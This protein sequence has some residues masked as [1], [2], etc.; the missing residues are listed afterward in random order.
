[1]KLKNKTVDTA[2]VAGEMFKRSTLP[3]IGVYARSGRLFFTGE[4]VKRILKTILLTCFVSNVLAAELPQ[5]KKQVVEKSVIEMCLLPGGSFQHDLY[6]LKADNV[7]IFALVDDFAE[8]VE[9]EHALPE[10]LSIE[11]PLSRQGEET[12]KISGGCIPESKN[13]AEVARTCNFFW[14]SIRS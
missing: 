5:C 14:G 4:I 11:F 1:L 9:L 12:T 3:K 8:K 6:T 13:G 7:L 2:A 10:G